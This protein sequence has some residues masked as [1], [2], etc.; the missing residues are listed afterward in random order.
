MPVALAF[1]PDGRLFFAERAGVVKVVHNGAV[2]EF[3]SV[4]TVTTEPGGGY[5]ER[6][7]LG[8]AI[9]PTF[10]QDRYVYAL[11]SDTDRSKQKVVR[12]TD[13]A[14][15]GTDPTDVIVLP[16][17]TSCCHKGGRIKFGTD[18]KLYVTL[19]DTQVSS[20]AQNTADMRGKVLRYNPD[21]TVPA[22]NPFGAGNPVWAFGFRNPFGLAIS[23]SGQMAVTSNGPTGDA[24]SPSTGYD[25]VNISVVKGGGYQW[26]R[27]YGYGHVLAPATSC[28]G[29]QH[30]P[31]WSSETRTVVPTG[32]TF[33]DSQ[34][35]SVAAGRLVFCT[36]N[37][38]MLILTPGD[39]HAT[40]A[41]GPADCEL[42]VV[43]APDHA[44]Y[45]S[46]TTRI[47]RLV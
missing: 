46:D 44:L 7:L 1:A 27:C 16:A 17:G 4:A 32:A 31:E 39:P 28:G 42:D 15:T 6:G 11:Y 14:G 25:T 38:G 30:D 2:K 19:G 13:C 10:G 43:Q 22:D 47:Y 9:S 23:S 3:A 20:A 5:S 8:L 21:G 40:V 35:P 34:G 36:F 12:W 41:S 33:V 18:G 24:G 45:F 37:T 29:D 26:P